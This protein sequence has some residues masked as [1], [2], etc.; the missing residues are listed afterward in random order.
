MKKP[1]QIPKHIQDLAKNA[2]GKGP[3]IIVNQNDTSITTGAN[4]NVSI[5]ASVNKTV[6]ESKTP[7]T[8]VFSTIAK[9]Y[10]TVKTTLGL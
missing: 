3:T 4:S 7:V 5:D 1:I 10:N 6:T 9:W 8:N 2:A